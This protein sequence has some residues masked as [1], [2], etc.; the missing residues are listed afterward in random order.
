MSVKQASRP[1]SSASSSHCAQIYPTECALALCVAQT[2]SADRGLTT[3]HRA[4][5]HPVTAFFAADEALA[6]F[7]HNSTALGP[8]SGGMFGT[9]VVSHVGVGRLGSPIIIP[10][11]L[12]HQ[13]LLNIF[14]TVSHKESDPVSALDQHRVL[15]SIV[16]MCGESRIGLEAYDCRGSGHFTTDPIMIGML[17]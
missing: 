1:R 17:M 9:D 7:D 10:V 3:C 14:S 8:D 4:S 6:K 15:S 13:K 5:R 2:S 16:D 12:Q 11:S